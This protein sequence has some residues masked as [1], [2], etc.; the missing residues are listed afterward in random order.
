V[1]LSR[2][3]ESDGITGRLIAAQWDPWPFA[4]D[5]KGQIDSPISTRFAVSFRRTAAVVGQD[6]MRLAIVGCGLIGGKRAAAA[7]GH[8]IVVVCDRDA[9]RADALATEDEGAR[10]HGTGGMPSRRMSMP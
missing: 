2:L 4:S 7:G 8:D 6:L 5:I 9:A 3:R 1:R 10:R